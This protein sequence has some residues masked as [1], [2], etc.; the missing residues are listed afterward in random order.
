MVPSSSSLGLNLKL[1]MPLRYVGLVGSLCLIG[2]L[3]LRCNVVQ[4]FVVKF[5]D[6]L[7]KTGCLDN[8][9]VS[10]KI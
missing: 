5:M 4:R 7:K 10:L 6:I 1:G 9:L 2:Y 3:Y 8:A